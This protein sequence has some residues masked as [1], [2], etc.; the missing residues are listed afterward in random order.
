[1]AGLLWSKMDKYVCIFVMIEVNNGDSFVYNSNLYFLLRNK[2]FL[3][4]NFSEEDSKE[5]TNRC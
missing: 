2:I 4:S 1:M 5:L 3:I